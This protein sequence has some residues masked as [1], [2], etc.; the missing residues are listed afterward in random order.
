MITKMKKFTFL[1]FYKDYEEFL[2]NIREL[3]V[4]HI[5]EKM[6]GTP[7]NAELQENIKLSSR[8]SATHKL[9]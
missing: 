9:L 2:L 5:A 7:D 3:G 8:I 4:V 6:Q 1:V